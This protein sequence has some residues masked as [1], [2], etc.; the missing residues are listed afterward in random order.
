MKVK[1]LLSIMRGDSLIV[2]E[3]TDC[4]GHTISRY[5]GEKD[6]VFTSYMDKETESLYISKG[7]IRIRCKNE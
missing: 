7:I 6:Y 4:S 3:E 5:R 2:V 1:E